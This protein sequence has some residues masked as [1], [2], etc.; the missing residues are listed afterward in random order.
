[1]HPYISSDLYL[2]YVTQFVS[3]GVARLASIYGCCMKSAT[4]VSV[5]S[6]E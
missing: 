4:G 3:R 1:M 5:T 6:Y 2:K